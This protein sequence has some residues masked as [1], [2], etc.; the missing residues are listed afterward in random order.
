MG[1]HLG[2]INSKPFYLLKSNISLDPKLGTT[3]NYLCI[4]LL[5]L[6][7]QGGNM[8]IERFSIAALEK[9]LEE[10]ELDVDKIEFI[11][12]EI[13]K[14]KNAI[15]ELKCEARKIEPAEIKLT[16]KA[17]NQ[18]SSIVELVNTD[19]KIKRK[20][21]KEIIKICEK[22]LRKE[23]YDYLERLENQLAYLKTNLEARTTWNEYSRN[24][25]NIANDDNTIERIIWLVG[26]ENL[27]KLFLCLLRDKYITEYSKEEILAHFADEKQRPFCQGKGYTMKI[28]WRKSDDSFAILISEMAKRGMIDNKNIDRIFEKHFVNRDGNSFKDLAQKRYNTKNFT[29]TG[30]NISKILDS[31]V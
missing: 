31:L 11:S 7:H 4:N 18:E 17:V 29:K 26:K 5:T 8:H 24:G 19:K 27:L 10:I 3:T 30:N 21:T 20:I 1:I 22:N 14:C 13:V 12:K 23:N 9:Q 2:K 28:R 25:N 16:A 6:F 15:Q